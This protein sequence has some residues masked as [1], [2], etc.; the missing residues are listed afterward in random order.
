M[1]TH[2]DYIVIGAGSAGCVVASRLSEDENVNVCLIEAGGSD[3]S[4]FVQMPTGLAISVPYGINSWHYETVPQSNLNNRCGFVPRGK[5]M[6]G[7]SS[8]NAMVYIRGNR[9]DYDHWADQGNEGWDFDSLLPYF[10]KAENNHS[11]NNDL[12]GQSG[13]LHVNELQC[14][15]HVNQF[16]LRGCH[17]NG[18]ALNSD[19]N[20]V[21]QKGCRLAQVTQ[22]N[23]ERCSAA[24]AYITPHLTRPNLTII[25]N[26]QVN[27]LALKNSSVVGVELLLRKQLHTLTA[28]HEVIVSAGAI[29]SPK[30]LLLSGI[31]D[32]EQ[33]AQYNIDSSVDLLGVGKNLQDHITIVPLYR[34]KQTSG[35]FGLSL[36]GGI[37]ILSEAFQW[38]KTRTGKMTSNFA[39]SHAFIKLSD[40]AVA[41]EIQ[42]EFVIGLVDDHSRKIHWGHGYSVHASLMRPKS[43][44]TIKLTSSDP[45]VPPLI[46]PNYLDHPDD[47]ST[48]LAGLKKTLDILES[49]AFD[50]IKGEM[51]YP[52]D[53]NND[54]QLLDFIKQTAD[55]EYHPVG[56]CKMGLASDN[57]A[58][59]DNQ[60]R[61]F[62]VKNLRVVDAS[63]M[64][65]IITGNT[66]GP[67]IAIAEK[68]AD[69]IKAS[70]ESRCHGAKR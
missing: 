19:I 61:V 54:E 21:V 14:P 42:L 25:T 55:T 2:F 31:G 46:D 27:R 17:D 39:E 20:G 44:G 48:L 24:K 68:A 37:S 28:Q 1:K 12:H 70:R 53:R 43:R 69:L 56:T 60:L 13:P 29:N 65:T 62:G 3:N 6:G 8:I 51:V 63:I 16:F 26:A 36:S 22:H 18:I 66:N 59:V 7:S 41:P 35:T 38:I 33:L 45:A 47:Q 30:L 9:W 4:A 52:L 23:G 5:V 34:A 67:V 10:I 32:K 58:V 57:C 49:S 40:N 11:I 50:E 15:S 64:P